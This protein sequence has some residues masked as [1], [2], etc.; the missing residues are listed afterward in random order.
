[1]SKLAMI[2]KGEK[3]TFEERVIENCD[4]LKKKSMTKYMRNTKKENQEHRELK[5][6]TLFK[7]KMQNTE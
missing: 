2:K 4:K 1:M 3:Q 5:A 7:I 6:T